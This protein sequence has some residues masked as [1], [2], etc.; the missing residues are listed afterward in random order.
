MTR[1]K[2]LVL[3]AVFLVLAKAGLWIYSGWGLITI[4]AENQPLWDVVASIERQGR[5]TL[6]S[7]I[8][9]ETPVTM[10]VKRVPLAEVLETLSVALDANWRL[11]Y[12]LAPDEASLNAA[13]ATSPA[14]RPPE[15]WKNFFYPLPQMFGSEEPLLVDPRTD[16]WETV[17]PA[18]KTLQAYLEN[19]AR[20]VNASFWLPETWNPSIANAP[21][22]GEIRPAVF[23]L[24][25][26]ARG[27]ITEIF[28]LS[29]FGRN[30][31]GG[32]RNEENRPVQN[33]VE[34]R[35]Q[36]GGGPR[37][38]EARAQAMAERVKAEIAKMPAAE[39]AQAQQEFDQQRVF[40]EQL[41]NLP[42]EERRAKMEEFFNDPKMQARW[43]N[44]EA[45][46][47]A[48]RTP[49]QRFDRYKNY[50]QRR[51]SSQGGGK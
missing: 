42:Q 43:E 1:T 28:V 19:A 39:R 29:S 44:R 25:K 15:G 9:P 38:D 33:S 3:A 10:H 24:A 31:G 8:A 4:D 11:Q 41:R 45:Q 5:I 17:A 22:S 34:N 27:Q 21:G 48:R 46:R 50:V 18:E 37:F 23:K 26:Q 47:D 12:V 6:R 49:E 7:S 32:P 40:W 30:R 16:R 51:F 14:G 13:L 35:V 20:S 2:W 36:G